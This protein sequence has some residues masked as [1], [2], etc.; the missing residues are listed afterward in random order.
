M[1]RD[2]VSRLTVEDPALFDQIA[3]AVPLEDHTLESRSPTER[4]VDPGFDRTLPELERRGLSVLVRNARARRGAPRRS[5]PSLDPL[6]EPAREL[7]DRALRHA[8]DGVVVGL[9]VFDP[10]HDEPLVDELVR[11]NLLLPLPSDDDDPL[12]RALARFALNPDLPPPAPLDW[13]FDEAVMPEP[14]DLEGIA[15]T[16]SSRATLGTGPVDLLHD[17][18]S[19]AAAIHGWRPKRT[20]AGPLTKASAR[21]LGH[22]LGSP[23]IEQSGA[24]E[25]DPRWGRALRALEGLGALSLD[26][27]RRELH[28]DLGLEEVLHGETSDAIDRLVHRLVDADLRPLL[29]VVRTALAQAHR[30]SSVEGD[31]GALDEVVF[32]DLIREQHRD[33]LFR[34]WQRM[35]HELYP[36]MGDAVVRRFDDDGFDEVEAPMIEA[37]LR[38]LHRL[39]LV[40]RAPGVFAATEDGREWAGVSTAQPPPPIWVSSDLEVVVPPRSLTPWE[41]MQL[42]RL[43]RCLGRDVVDRFGIEKARV[44]QW[45]A[46]HAIEEALALLRARA[47]A[48]PTTVE[49]TLSAWA[50][51]AER[52]V[53]ERGLVEDAPS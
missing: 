17:V 43:G 47:Q 2:V 28:L 8:R 18:A 48:L 35:G 53:L 12:P 46:D 36:V 22:R 10:Q 20:L 42:E 44:R 13:D 6:S 4:I 1:T 15:D 9:H 40:R 19:L 38:R 45:L 41:R 3:L 16:A 26:A 49:E 5:P 51:S 52:I 7:L 32:A 23:A 29:P 21:K 11:A 24:L 25:A 27:V 31:P 14:D 39:G 50:R 37:V 34:P 33:L 30:S